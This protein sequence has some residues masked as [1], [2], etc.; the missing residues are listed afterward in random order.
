MKSNSRK[1]KRK[2]GKRAGASKT[3]SP[4]HGNAG[5]HMKKPSKKNKQYKKR[6]GGG[7]KNLTK[8][9]IDALDISTVQYESHHGVD[10]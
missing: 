6:G 8:S 7:V 4:M 10:R 3:N 2:R 1:R 5:T 9:G